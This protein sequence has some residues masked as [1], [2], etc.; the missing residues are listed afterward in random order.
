MDLEKWNKLIFDNICIDNRC[1]YKGVRHPM[2]ESFSS[3]SNAGFVPVMAF[4][5]RV[6]SRLKA[7][8]WLIDC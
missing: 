3:A 5:R 8:W 2:P 6:P 4:R 1:L 7:S